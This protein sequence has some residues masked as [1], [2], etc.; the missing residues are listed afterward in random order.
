MGAQ[1]SQAD[2]A[3]MPSSVQEQIRRQMGGQGRG[4]AFGSGSASVE[5]PATPGTQTPLAAATAPFAGRGGR[6]QRTAQSSFVP[7]ESDQ[8]QEGQGT[9]APTGPPQSPDKTGDQL[10]AE[11]RAAGADRATPLG[12]GALPGVSSPSADVRAA[13]AQRSRAYVAQRSTERATMTPSPVPVHP[14]QFGPSPGFD[15]HEAMRGL[16]TARA[17]G[18]LAA[19]GG[20]RNVLPYA[21]NMHQAVGD[22]QSRSGESL[23]ND[24]RR[25]G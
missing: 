23:W 3:K 19:P 10:R 6:P 1:V 5:S 11:A 25:R 17:L 24:R 21:F 9:V 12:Q 20:W 7:G 2:I 16:R 4:E 18:S 14:T 13:S 22:S 15:P 8:I